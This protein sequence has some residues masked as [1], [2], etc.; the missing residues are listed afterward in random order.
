MEYKVIQISLLIWY[1]L[2]SVLDLTP[3]VQFLSRT[4][5]NKNSNHQP[6]FLGPY[7]MEQMNQVSDLTVNLQDINEIYYNF[8]SREF[9]C[10]FNDF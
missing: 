4:N 1:Y 9:I 5:P 8:H 10:R 3:K 7:I 2:E 6:N